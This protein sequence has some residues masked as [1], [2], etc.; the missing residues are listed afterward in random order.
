MN[1][2]DK[3]IR[4]LFEISQK[5]E[6]EDFEMFISYLN[7]NFPSKKKSNLNPIY[8][9]CGELS[10]TIEIFTDNQ[11]AQGVLIKRFFI[12]NNYSL[13][14]SLNGYINDD[15]PI[16]KKKLICRNLGIELNVNKSLHPMVIMRLFANHLLPDNEILQ[17]NQSKI[18][19]STYTFTYKKEFNKE[20]LLA[21]YYE[22]QVPE[23]Q[24]DFMD[25]F[26][27]NSFII[28]KKYSFIL[29]DDLNKKLD[30]VILNVKVDCK[31]FI[32]SK[33][34]CIIFILII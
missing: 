23:N 27:L 28:K 12:L 2:P 22:N 1:G 4:I 8:T 30:I 20:M 26:Y 14:A 9:N 13:R 19:P 17:I 5:V 6:L 16:D 25:C 7:E 11:I 10:S 33:R 3:K 24:K 29:E 32:D 15:Y 18:F 34:Y 31:Y 21:K